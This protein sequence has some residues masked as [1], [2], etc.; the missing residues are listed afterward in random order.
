MPVES[1]LHVPCAEG[2]GIT[3]YQQQ[4]VVREKFQ[5]AQ[6]DVVVRQVVPPA[7]HSEIATQY[8][9][10]VDEQ[11]CGKDIGN[12]RSACSGAF[13]PPGEAPG[14]SLYNHDYVGSAGSSQGK[15]EGERGHHEDFHIEEPQRAQDDIQHPGQGNPGKYRRTYHCCTQ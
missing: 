8:R 13:A 4:G 10:R 14:N 12:H 3:A 11:D 5:A 9:R 2:V 15:Q 6:G 7:G 1:T